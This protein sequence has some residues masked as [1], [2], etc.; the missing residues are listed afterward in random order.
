MKTKLR[1]GLFLAGAALA[2]VAALVPE[3]A[4]GRP[5]SCDRSNCP[6]LCC[7][8]AGCDGTACNDTVCPPECR[9]C[10]STSSECCAAPGSARASVP[11]AESGAAAPPGAAGGAPVQATRAP[12]NAGC[13]EPG[14]CAT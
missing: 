2:L 9:P 12:S 10:A 11:G 1:T 4:A 14:C 8:G 3:S 5:V 6:P 7:D 13:C